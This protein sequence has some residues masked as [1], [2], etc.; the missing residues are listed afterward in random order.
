MRRG[1]LITKEEVK[2]KYCDAHKAELKKDKRARIRR[3]LNDDLEYFYASLQNPE[4]KPKAEDS[5]SFLT[6]KLTEEDLRLVHEK[7][8]DYSNTFSDYYLLGPGKFADD[9]KKMKKSSDPESKF[10]YSSCHRL[11]SAL[12]VTLKSMQ[13][14]MRKRAADEDLSHMELKKQRVNWYNRSQYTYKFV[15]KE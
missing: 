1:N 15:K 3:S 12:H 4:S 2:Q 14:E 13:E 8:Q 11:T 7:N 6:Q 5:Y 10:S 9:V